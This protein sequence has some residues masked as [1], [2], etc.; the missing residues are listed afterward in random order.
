MSER[1]LAPVGGIH[2]VRIAL[3][4]DA[5]AVAEIWLERERRDRRLAELAALAQQAGVRIRQ[6]ARAELDAVGD[7]LNHQGALAW[8]RPRAPGRE[9][10]LEAILAA[11]AGPPLLLI[12]DEVQD[13]HNLGACL[14]TADAAGVDAVIAPRDNAVGLTPVVV[15][16]ASGAAATVPYI[17]VT[18]LARTMAALQARGV[19]LIGTAGEADQALFDADLTGPLALVMGSEGRGLRRLTRERCDGLVRLP[20]LG[21][22]ESLNVSVATG[23]CLYEALRQRR[24]AAP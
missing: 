10:D 19:W 2:S 4:S 3:R 12:L 16:V 20:M 13:P 9:A 18:N 8:V 24:P 11:A 15:K 17:Q 7:G 14:R 1:D 22:V 23:I 21:R 5:D 6:V